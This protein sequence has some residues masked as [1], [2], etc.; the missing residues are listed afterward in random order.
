MPAPALFRLYAVGRALGFRPADS[1]RGGCGARR[2][3]CSRV[4]R[5]HGKH[6]DSETDHEDRR[7]LDVRPLAVAGGTFAMSHNFRIM[8][9]WVPYLIKHNAEL[10]GVPFTRNIRA[11]GM[12]ATAF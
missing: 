3:G 11:K 4:R 12:T 9:Q 2:P 1:W 5:D 7:L 8:F 10:C 6:H